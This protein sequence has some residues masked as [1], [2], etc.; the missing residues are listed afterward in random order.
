MKLGEDTER[1]GADG[2]EFTSTGECFLGRRTGCRR[3]S[4]SRF[5]MASPR[6][7]GVRVCS[8]ANAQPERGFRVS[9]MEKVQCDI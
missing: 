8:G 3:G 9:S 7:G 2:R 6:P 5:G 4:C 1:R